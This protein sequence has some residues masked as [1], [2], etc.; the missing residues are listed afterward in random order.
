M[1]EHV[2]HFWLDLM[3]PRIEI[4]MEALFILSEIFDFKEE[5]M[6]EAT[7]ASDILET[8][9]QSTKRV[10]GKIEPEETPVETR[11]G[12]RSSVARKT[13]V[14]HSLNVDSKVGLVGTKETSKIIVESSRR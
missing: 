10:T 14:T 4:L 3:H 8:V 2:N 11:R 12:R 9:G 7:V 1:H 5:E 13:L 6:S